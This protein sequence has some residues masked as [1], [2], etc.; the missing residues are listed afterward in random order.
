MTTEE[1]RGFKRLV[2]CLDGTWNTRDDNT[3]IFHIANLVADTDPSGT[4]Q[5]V[6]YDPGVGTGML[7][8]FSGGVFGFGINT[9]IREAYEWL[10]ANYEDG[11]QI[12]I[13]GFSRGAYTARTLGGML[14]KVGLLSPGA[15]LTVL[16][17]WE[18]YTLIGRKEA[19]ANWW[20]TIFGKRVPPCRPLIDLRWDDGTLRVSELNRTE[21]L[22]VQWCRRP[23]IHCMGVFDTVG[24]LGWDTLAVPWLRTRIAHFHNANLNVLIRNGFQAL[25]IDEHRSMFRCIPWRRYI[26]TGAEA[27]SGLK[28]GQVIEQR[29]FVGAHSNIG[30]GYAD[31]PLA[32]FPLCWMMEKCGPLGA[33]LHFKQNAIKRPS[34]SDCVPLRSVVPEQEGEG[35]VTKKP[36]LRDSY[37]EFLPRVLRLLYRQYFRTLEAPPRVHAGGSD[38]SIGESIDP[39]V[40]EFYRADSDYRPRNYIEYC[41]RMK[42]PLP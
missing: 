10:V 37:A 20:E 33:G 18:A 16:Q 19:K 31:N 13:F 39:S 15:P 28:A 38:V 8:S 35:F 24:A 29:W 40:D 14:A 5:L 27:T 6:Y 11:D 9:N 12:F 22:M 26:P 1:R 21:R 3:S 4:R 42:K 23:P 2:I 34:V 30:G 25:A 17:L 41:S 7:D 36:F 32:L